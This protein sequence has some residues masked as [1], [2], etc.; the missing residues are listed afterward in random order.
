MSAP[1]NHPAVR[2]YRRAMLPVYLAAAEAGA[3]DRQFDGGEWSDALHDEAV[4]A[5]EWAMAERIAPRFGLP[6]HALIDQAETAAAVEGDRAM[7]ALMGWEREANP[8]D[9]AAERALQIIRDAEFALGRVLSNGQRADLLLDNM[10]A[11][12]SSADA[13]AL[14]QS[15]G[16]F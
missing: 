10:P 11:L 5:A 2:A 6:A 13:F 4:L 8:R 16:G 3:A 7:A 15:L 9:S 14:L 1:I 12:K